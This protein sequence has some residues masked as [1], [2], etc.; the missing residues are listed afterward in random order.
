MKNIGL[1][2]MLNTC[3]AKKIA[4]ERHEYMVRFLEEFNKEWDVRLWKVFSMEHVMK[5]QGEKLFLKMFLF[6]LPKGKKSG[7]LV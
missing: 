3:T 1:Q 6:P 7:L 4:S 5:T 2:D